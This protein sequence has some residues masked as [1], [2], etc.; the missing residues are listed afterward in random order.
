MPCSGLPSRKSR[1]HPNQGSIPDARSGSLDPASALAGRLIERGVGQALDDLP[2]LP[3]EPVP[4]L[5]ADFFL[6]DPNLPGPGAILHQGNGVADDAAQFR[7]AERTA[8]TA[9]GA[10][11]LQLA[12]QLRAPLVTV[13][14]KLGQAAKRLLATDRSAIFPVGAPNPEP[15]IIFLP[16]PAFPC[17]PETMDRPRPGHS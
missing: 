4:G 11:Y 8:L 16:S 14:K 2:I 10:A 1:R 9:Y 5:A 12:L 15:M 6:L 13:D 3:D 7:L 17:T